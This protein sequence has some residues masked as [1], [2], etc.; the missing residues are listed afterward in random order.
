VQAL[1]GRW[2]NQPEVMAAAKESKPDIDH[3]ELENTDAGGK[4]EEKLVRVHGLV[5]GHVATVSHRSGARS[6]MGP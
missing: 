4:G 1:H 5:C 6:A 2:R 3:V